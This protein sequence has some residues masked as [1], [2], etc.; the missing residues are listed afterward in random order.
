MWWGGIRTDWGVSNLKAALHPQHSAIDVWLGVGSQKRPPP[1]DKG[2]G[3][4]SL[5]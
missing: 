2:R 1:V 3:V 4:I 5:G